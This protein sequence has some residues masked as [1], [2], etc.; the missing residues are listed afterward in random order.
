MAI[1]KRLRFEI[2]RRDDHT[3]RYCGARAPEATLTVDHIVAV[4]LGGGDDPSNLVTACVDCNAGKSSVP[5]DAPLVAQVADDAIRWAEAMRV[6]AA[7]MIGDVGE[8][9]RHLERFDEAWMATP[10]FGGEPYYRPADW[11][12]SIEYWLRA[13]VPIEK[14]VDLVH[15]ILRRRGI[16]GDR[17]R[18]FAGAAHRTVDQLQEAAR[19]IVAQA[20]SATADEDDP[21]DEVINTYSLY[22]EAWTNRDAIGITSLLAPWWWLTVHATTG[23]PY[24]VRGPG[25]GWTADFVRLDDGTVEVHWRAT[26]VDDET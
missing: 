24:V 16:S 11:D 5:A 7:R 25:E 15:S 8:L 1:S 13:G 14:L 10:R 18:Y 19:V 3:C 26:P 17:W 21:Q 20:P 9:H 2:Y 23:G 4:A 12:S 6:A 22:A